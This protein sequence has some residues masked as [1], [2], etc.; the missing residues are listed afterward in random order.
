MALTIFKVDKHYTPLGNSSYSKTILW[1]I[2]ILTKPNFKSK[3]YLL[4]YHNSSQN[5][6]LSQLRRHCGRRPST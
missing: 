1:T 6:A 3:S 2:T 5:I 4:D